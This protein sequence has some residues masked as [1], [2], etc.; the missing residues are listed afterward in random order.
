MN[1]NKLFIN[2]CKK[3]NLERNSNQLDLIEKLNQFYNLNF[4]K[5]FLKKIFSKNNSK[6]GFYLQGDVGVGKTMILNF[7]YENFKFTK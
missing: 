5:S 6:L 2:Y 7:F 3:N 1:L 4:N